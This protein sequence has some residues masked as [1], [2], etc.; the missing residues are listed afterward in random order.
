MEFSS[1]NNQFKNSVKLSIADCQ[2]GIQV[3][4][5][6]MLDVE[7][8]QKELVCFY[9]K[10]HIFNPSKDR[11]E[12]NELMEQLRNYKKLFVYFKKHILEFGG[13]LS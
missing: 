6:F 11:V 7:H 2:K 3:C 8:Y 12:A 13:R 1:H 5:N 4:Q 10:N 9:C